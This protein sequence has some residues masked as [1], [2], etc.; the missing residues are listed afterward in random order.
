MRYFAGKIVYD[1]NNFIN[2]RFRV[3]A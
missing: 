1:T 2:Q 3:L